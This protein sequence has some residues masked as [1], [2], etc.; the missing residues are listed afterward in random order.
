MSIVL[1]G[2]G[3]S[4]PPRENGPILLKLFFFYPPTEIKHSSDFLMIFHYFSK[5]K[6]RKMT[7]KWKFEKN[8]VEQ[9]LKTKILEKKNSRQLRGRGFP[10]PTIPTGQYSSKTQKNSSFRRFWKSHSGS[11]LKNL[12]P[13]P[14][15]P[16]WKISIKDGFL[17]PYLL[18]EWPFH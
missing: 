13:L 2:F 11:T 6:N 15:D 10:I 14:I 7:K 17:A 3:F 9:N 4:R 12:R 18:D 5:P 16:A 8:Q 1:A